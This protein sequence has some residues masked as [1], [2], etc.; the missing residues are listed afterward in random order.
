MLERI[1]AEDNLY[2]ESGNVRDLNAAHDMAEAEQ[3][4]REVNAERLFRPSR[5]ELA[6]QEADLDAIG[7]KA[8]AEKKRQREADDKWELQE[9]AALSLH[10]QFIER[11]LRQDGLSQEAWRALPSDTQKHLESGWIRREK[12][13]PEWRLE[14]RLKSLM[15]RKVI[16]FEVGNLG[17]VSV[18]FDD[19]SVLS[20]QSWNGRDDAADYDAIEV[21]EEGSG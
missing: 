14:Q 3:Y 9:Q 12:R 15:G 18:L 1:P 5:K 2:N 6:E 11:N 20:F 21:R 8:L 17:N 7:W 16:S 19:G 10:E 13:S 4:Y